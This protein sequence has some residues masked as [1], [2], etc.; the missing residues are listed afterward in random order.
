MSATNEVMRL[1]E[2]IAEL[3]SEIEKYKA[4]EME[5][6]ML[7]ADVE[8]YQEALGLF[9][10]EGEELKKLITKYKELKDEYEGESDFLKN[11]VCDMKMFAFTR[12]FG[13]RMAKVYVLFDFDEM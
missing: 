12:N 2:K 9:E 7:R 13:G 8:D 11:V 4:V 5:N 3:E 1:H 10:E 6:D